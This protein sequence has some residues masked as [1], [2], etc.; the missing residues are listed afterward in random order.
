MIS[1]KSFSLFILLLTLLST[2]TSA[3]FKPVPGKEYR[4]FY[5][6]V[7]PVSGE[8]ILGVA[9]APSKSTQE[10]NVVQVYFPHEW[11]GQVH[12]QTLSS[13]GR[14][15]GE[16][17]YSGTTKGK[18]WVPLLLGDTSS[19]GSTNINTRP[20]GPESL[21]IS[22]RDPVGNLHLVWWSA[23][24]P[25]TSRELIR[26]YVNTRRADAFL[27][28]E[29]TVSPKMCKSLRSGQTIRFDAYCD[30]TASDIPPSGEMLLIRRANFVDETQKFKIV[31]H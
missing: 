15:R 1:K 14:F 11:S 6:A 8:A 31:V 19:A 2:S 10:D 3:Q 9:L 20:T 17:L 30:L 7:N 24:P 13:D 29:T 16:G 28:S 25:P 23:N 4:E 22:A 21:A 18:E 26:F 27:T 12:I 5:D